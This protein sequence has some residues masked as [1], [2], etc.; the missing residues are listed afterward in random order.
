M[1]SYVLTLHLLLRICREVRRKLQF[2][3]RLT[4]DGL[5]QQVHFREFNLETHSH[6]TMC[7]DRVWAVID[8]QLPRPGAGARIPTSELWG[9]T[10]LQSMAHA[11][12]LRVPSTMRWL[13]S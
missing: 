10:N 11:P 3:L 8:D 7:R 12:P 2:S 4:F 13:L 1:M 9:N 6:T 5:I